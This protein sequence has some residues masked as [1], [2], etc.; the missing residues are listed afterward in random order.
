[1]VSKA[2]ATI[3]LTLA[4]PL[5]ASAQDAKAVIDAASKAMGA[6]TLKTVE[7]SGSGSDYVFGQAYSPTSPWPR[8]TDKTY[9]RQIDFQAPASRMDRVRVQFE[10]PPRGGGQ[11]PIRGDQMQNQT[12]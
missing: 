11:Q 2:L 4:V 10:N 1:M 7:Y 6:D 3:V 5:L 9:T 12:I 8:F